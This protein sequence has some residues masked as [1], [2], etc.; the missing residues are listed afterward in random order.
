MRAL[1]LLALPALLALA[2][3]TAAPGAAGAAPAPVAAA[4][5][6]RAPAAIELGDRLRA[7]TACHGPEGRASR[8][9][10]LPRI[11]GK[12]AGYLADQLI[13]FRDGRRQ[14]AA[15]QRLLAPLTDD[16]LR[17][18]A[19]HFAAIELPYPPPLPVV[20]SAAELARGEALVRQGDPARRIPACAACHGEALLGAQPGVPGLLGLP[21]DYLNAQLGAWKSGQ[22][23][24]AEPD[25]MATV[26]RALQPED[27]AAVSSWLASRPV[28]AGARPLSAPR[29]DAPLDCG[30]FQTTPR[31]AAAGGPPRGE[32]LAR[33]G[34][35]VACHTAPGGPPMAGGRA[36]ETPFG[37]VY[38][39]NLTPDAAT[40]IGAWRAADFRRAMHEGRSRD[41][42]LLSPAFPYTSTTRMAPADVDAI[43]DWLRTLAPVARPT[44]PH[45]MRWPFGSPWAIA[46]WRW[47]NFRPAS[48]AEITAASADRGRYLVEVLGHCDA[49]HAPRDALGAVR[50]S[51]GLTGG[52]V[53][54]GRWQAPSLADPREAGVQDW[55]IDAIVA[56][57]RDGHV[58]IAGSPAREGHARSFSALGPMAEVVRQGTAWLPEADLRAMATWLQALPRVAAPSGASARSAEPSSAAA[59]A[60]TAAGIRPPSG[61][62]GAALYREHCADC[63]GEDGRGRPGGAWPALAGNRAV[64]LAR[65]DNLIAVVLEG[66]FAP[67][68]AGNPRPW[69][70]PPFG[71]RLDDAELADLLSHVRASWG[72][73]A[74]PVSP[75]QVQ[76]ARR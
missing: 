43:F 76:R 21:R 28:A 41:G 32:I 35:C 16:Y 17:E 52:W 71:H 23:R 75:Q 50:E 73:G 26:A 47:V 57:L 59:S 39:S 64:G 67:A 20:A 11:A 45:A 6:T 58:S 31:A 2:I 27:I 72:D 53:G 10:Y 29:P 65:P 55:P 8:E 19:A 48:P 60:A 56:L 37:T 18:I 14:H 61:T 33:A 13:A 68:T 66:G 12:P 49:C 54:A 38:S 62:R 63:H 51:R 70:M 22:R 69:G 46:A 25:C 4:A 15:M 1:S 34:N 40:G 30:S 5:S 3:A 36:I 42:R 7:C 74:G 24:S 9:G 44:P